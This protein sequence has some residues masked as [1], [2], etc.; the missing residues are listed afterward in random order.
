MRQARDVL[1]RLNALDRLAFGIDRID[2]AAEA[3]ADQVAQHGVADAGGRVA[4]PDDGDAVGIEDLVEVAMLTG[5]S[6]QALERLQARRTRGGVGAN[7]S[8]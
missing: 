2:H 7:P 6:W 4:G 8:L 1:V 5:G 3:R